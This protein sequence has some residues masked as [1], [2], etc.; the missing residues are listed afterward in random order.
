MKLLI[1]D[2]EAEAADKAIGALRVQ[3]QRP[4]QGLTD[5]EVEEFECADVLSVRA[6]EAK[7]KE[8]NGG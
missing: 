5:E 1:E 2:W 4:W 3:R 7:L 8:R 6:I